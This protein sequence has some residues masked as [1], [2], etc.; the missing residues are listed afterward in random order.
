MFWFCLLK[1]KCVFWGF[2]FGFDAEGEGL[3]THSL[4]DRNVTATSKRH[5]LLSVSEIHRKGG[6]VVSAVRSR[7]PLEQGPGETRAAPLVRIE[8]AQDKDVYRWRPKT[9]PVR[10][11]ERA[12]LLAS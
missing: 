3:S 7:Q 4:V 6:R 8:A 9:T 5:Q 10:V 12:P 2:R 11:G 1:K